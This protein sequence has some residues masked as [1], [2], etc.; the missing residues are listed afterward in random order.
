[1]ELQHCFKTLGYLTLVALAAI[2]NLARRKTNFACNQTTTEF[3]RQGNT[4]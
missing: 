4:T 2:L 1:M 3:V